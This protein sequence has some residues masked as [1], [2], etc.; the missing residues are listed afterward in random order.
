MILPSFEEFSRAA[1]SFPIVPVFDE[2]LIDLETPV[3]AFR[4]LASG[5]YVSLLESLE[6]GEH[7]GRY[8]MIGCDPSLVFES[9]GR[10]VTVI[11]GERRR[12]WEH[13]R[14]LKALD[15]L[16]AEYKTAALPGLPPLAGGAI[17]FA[18]YDIVRQF[19]RLPGTPADDLGVPDARYVFFETMVLFDHQAH[20]V[21]VVVNARHGGD[22]EGTYRRATERI[23]DISRR[24][25]APDPA[26]L[27]AASHEPVRFTSTV[28]Q[29]QFQAAVVRAKE[30]I[31]A[32]DVVQVVLAHRLE[33]PVSADP[34]D[35]YRA[36]RVINPSPY[37]F[38]LK[39][40][41][42][43]VVGSSPEVLVRRVGR[44]I[45]TRPIA[46]TRPRGEGDL[47]D[48]L[49]EEE[50]RASEKERAEHMMLVDLGRNDLGRICGY[51]SV[52][53]TEFMVVERYSHV[54]HL[55]SHIVGDLREGFSNADVL[56][57][58]FPAGTV[59]GAPKIRAMEIIDEL[60][61]VRRGI[62][63]GAIGYMDFHGNMDTC[64]AIRTLVLREGRAYLG[65]GAG[66]VSDSDPESEYHETM[67][68]GSALIRACELA[69]E[70]LEAFSR[71]RSRQPLA[72]VP[73]RSPER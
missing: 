65:I 60:E 31:R 11:E 43:T 51:G 21:K 46:G 10:Q 29:E 47:A 25:S 61:P 59:S 70:G 19:E 49:L 48:R 12:S 54:M 24:L 58:C 23:R 15:E 40:G 4:K 13:D 50:L 62:Y 35:I 57:A 63:A 71:P 6:G 14:P 33:S 9:R 38:Y 67:R 27:E 68:K 36:L 55:V 39:L 16:L 1:A 52:K 41:D 22:P 32:G 73:A 45:E 37:L 34:F 28:S 30:Y 2:L 72:A 18:S 42:L 44:T 3:S 69:H 26:P 7:W 66:I 56:E 17:G 8:S 5:G 64:I 20:T 53:T